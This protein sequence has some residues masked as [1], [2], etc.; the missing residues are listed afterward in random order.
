MKTG[1]GAGLTSPLWAQFVQLFSLLRQSLWYN[2]FVIIVYFWIYFW[3]VQRCLHISVFISSLLLLS[4]IFNCWLILCCLFVGKEIAFKRS[5]ANLMN[6][7]KAPTWSHEK[8]STNLSPVYTCVAVLSATQV[9]HNIPIYNPLFCPFMWVGLDSS[10][11]QDMY[12][13][14]DVPTEQQ[15]QWQRSPVEHNSAAWID[16][17]QSSSVSSQWPAFLPEPLRCNVEK[18]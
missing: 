10:E 7:E 6:S 8:R 11:P 18:H 12:V 17:P 4:F 3:S 5:V 2:T 16:H 9:Y 13:D 14:T 1:Q 15:V